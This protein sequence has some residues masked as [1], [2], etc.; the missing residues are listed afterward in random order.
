MFSV[1]VRSGQTI[2]G[3]D[4]EAHNFL[5]QVYTLNLETFKRI[6]QSGDQTKI[7]TAQKNFGSTIANPFWQNNK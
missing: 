4:K 6:H 3:K 5:Q 2:E 1:N 7:Q